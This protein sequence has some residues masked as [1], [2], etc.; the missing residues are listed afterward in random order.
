[1]AFFVFWSRKR[2]AAQH[3][4]ANSILIS[5]VNRRMLFSE[6]F[7]PRELSST[8]SK[9]KNRSAAN[10]R[11]FT[12]ARRR[13]SVKCWVPKAGQPILKRNV[14]LFPAVLFVFEHNRNIAGI[15]LAA[16]GA[17]TGSSLT[18]TNTTE[19]QNIR[20]GS[21]I[22]AVPLRWRPDWGWTEHR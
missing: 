16:N 13:S 10:V 4:C 21:R 14:S 19:S 15:R 8:S 20:R 22:P 5:R 12:E 3:F 11:A 6:A 2:G 9:R 18:K 1:M 7:F 17:T